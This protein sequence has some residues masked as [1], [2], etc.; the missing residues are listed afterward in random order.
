MISARVRQ[1]FRIEPPWWRDLCDYYHC[2]KRDAAR[3]GRRAPGR[4]PDFSQWGGPGGKTYEELWAAAPRETPEQIASF[5]RELGPWPVFRQVYRRRYGA[6]PDVAR[7]LP[8]H[9]RLI[10]YGCGIAPVTWWLA[11]R[12][13]DFTA[14]LADVRGQAPEFGL[15]RLRR[16]DM[17]RVMHW[18]AA[19]QL[20]PRDLRPVDVVTVLETLEHVPA[21]LAV[22]RA[23][24][25]ALVPGGVLHEDFV[26]H[27]HGGAPSDLP[28][29][30]AERSAVHAFL[31]QSCTLLSGRSPETPGGG[32][33][34][35][36]RKR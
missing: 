1:A 2:T 22:I 5:Y 14:I 36:W 23:L 26:S 21:P 25:D 4:C 24:V 28:S 6:W 10:E 18:I 34:R 20:L 27:E 29:A 17:T 30:Q 11:Q 31:R 19:D 12:R 7:D 9:G 8:P 32:D 3:L 13:Q 15:W 16:S 33:V 35:R